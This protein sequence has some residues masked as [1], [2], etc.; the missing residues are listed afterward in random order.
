MQPSS[1]FLGV[2]SSWVLTE[3]I[4]GSAILAEIVVTPDKFLTNFIDYD[5]QSK[6][7][8][9]DGSESDSE[10]EADLYQLSISLVDENGLYSE[11]T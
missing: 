8:S 7:V 1:V 3:V 5:A 2:A 9:F 11:Y 10:L 4:V 6:T